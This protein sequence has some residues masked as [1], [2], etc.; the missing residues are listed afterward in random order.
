[1]ASNEATLLIRIKQTGI[2]AL[3]KIKSAMGFVAEKAMYVGAAIV[4]LGV[5][6]IHSFGEAEKATNALNQSMV[7]QGIYTAELSKKYQEMAEHLESVT[8]FADDQITSAQALM[9]AQLGQTQIT[10][11]LMRATL[12]LA[13][14]KGMDLKSAADMVGKTI[15]TETNALARQGIVL[16]E[17]ATKSEKLASV[18]SQ[19]NSKFGGQAEAQAKGLGSLEQLKNAADNFLEKI[20]SRLAPFITF[21]TRQLIDFSRSLENNG[22][23]LRGVDDT[24]MFISKSFVY[25][26]NIVV[27]LAEVWGTGLSAAIE[28]VSLA[29]HGHFSDAKAMASLGM[30][31]IGNLV[32]ERKITLDSELAEIEN[33]NAIAAEEKRQAE[34]LL[35]QQNEEAKAAKARESAATQFTD[36]QMAM[37]KMYG[38]TL[39]N[40]DDLKKLNDAELKDRDAFLGQVSSLQ[41]SH[42]KTLAAIGKAAALAQVTINTGDAAMSGYRWGMAVG[43]PPLAS[44]FAG[45]AI[46]AGAAQAA[47]ISGVQLADGGIVKPSPG[48]TQATIGEGGQAEMVVPLDQAASMGFGGGGTTVIFQ[49]PVLGNESQAMEFARAIDR[50]L[51]KLRQSNQAVAFDTDVI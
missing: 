20:G 23:V 18:I 4:A 39:K 47:R 11:Q 37:A 3:D 26:K 30:D 5:A 9:Q 29:M 19:L 2:E 44:V 16:D 49:G 15:G 25:L 24:I 32:K 43:G 7:A 13:A 36:K 40:K 35:I 46:A 42:N 14:A 17:A 50:S 21:F 27:G 28:S 12:D 10:E 34:L 51:L 22:S 1:M 41:S 48:G 31:E 6:A 38:I 33:A 45:L 8:T